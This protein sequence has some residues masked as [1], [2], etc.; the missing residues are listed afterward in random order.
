MAAGSMRL[1]TAKAAEMDA[2]LIEDEADQHFLSIMPLG[3]KHTF[4]IDGWVISGMV[5]GRFT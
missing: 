1:D 2:R 4:D 3:L 5:L